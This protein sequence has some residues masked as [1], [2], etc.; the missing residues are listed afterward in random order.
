VSRVEQFEQ[1]RRDHAREELSIRELARRHG[2]HRRAV[3]QA[4]DSAIPSP[5]SAPEVRPAPKLGRYRAV[6]DA[7][8][9][10]DRDAPRKQRHTARR[11]WQ[12]LVEEHG[13]VVSERQVCRYV[14]VKRRELG[15][16]G[17]V[18][19]PL[20]SDAGVEAEVDWGQAKIMLRGE[21]VEVHL[22]QMRA[23]FSGAAFVM[24]FR[25]ETQQAFLEGHVRALEWHAGVFDVLRYDNLKSA[26]VRV[27]KGRRRVES[28]RFVALRS[29]YRFESSFCL[30]GQ[31][32]AHEKGGVEGEI[33]RFRRRHLVPVPEVS[34]LEELNERLEEACWQDLERTITGQSETVGERRDRERLLLSTLPKEPHPTWEEATPRVDAKALATV[35]TNRYSVPASLASL[36]IRAR[37][38]AAEVS[39]WHD[40]KQVASHERLTGHHQISAQLDHYL[41]LLT[42]KPGALARSL[43]LRQERDRGDWPAC[44]DQLW[45]AIQERSGRQE[46]ARQM[47]EVLLLCR[48]HPAD[49]VELAVKGAL[50]AGAHDGRAVKLLV[51]RSARP[52]PPALEIDAKLAG[53]GQPPPDDLGEYDQLRDEGAGL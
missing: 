22:F 34:S 40:G 13:A 23:C 44:F 28:D 36:K 48:T 30:P 29:H 8:L 2:V 19:V 9:V 38:G 39:F 27:L 12:R 37:V 32:G 35:R 33:G 49:Q 15:V 47:V 52:Q 6:I 45:T 17:E 1:I 53:I 20:I 24:A 50:A 42:R 14:R 41:D 43:A 26:V 25:D 21:S 31:K 7:W 18:F 16:V 5:K 3:R 11:I 46:A 51:D 4:L 10:A